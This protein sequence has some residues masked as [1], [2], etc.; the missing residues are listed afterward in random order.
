M[1]LSPSFHGGVFDVELVVLFPLAPPGPPSPGSVVSFPVASLLH[2]LTLTFPLLKH[3]FFPASPPRGPTHALGHLCANSPQ[4]YGAPFQALGADVP[5]ASWSI[6]I[7][8]QMFGIILISTRRPQNEVIL[9]LALTL[10][11]SM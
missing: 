11:L 6:T 8:I 4:R 1:N 5:K 10:F 9:F 2:P 3:R 7:F